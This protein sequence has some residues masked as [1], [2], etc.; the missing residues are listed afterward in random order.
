MADVCG[1]QGGVLQAT[2]AMAQS[3]WIELNMV[4]II[5]WSDLNRK[6]ISSLDLTIIG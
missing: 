1:T 6:D 3:L 5:I 2:K 4:S